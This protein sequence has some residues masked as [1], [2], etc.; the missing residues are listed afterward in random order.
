MPISQEYRRFYVD[1]QR[2]GDY[3]YWQAGQAEVRGA[4][5]FDAIA[6]QVPSRF[7]TLDYAKT[8]AGEEVVVELGDCTGGWSPPG[9]DG[10]RFL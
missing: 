5:P 4:D 6:L 3:P 9:L 8:A 2:L 10:L 1:G 7:F